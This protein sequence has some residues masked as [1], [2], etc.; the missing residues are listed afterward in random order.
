MFLLTKFIH[1]KN[2]DDKA[3]N[4]NGR[5]IYF[6]KLPS[7]NVG[8]DSEV[9]QKTGGSARVTEFDKLTKGEAVFDNDSNDA[10][11]SR[12][13]T[14]NN[15]IEEEKKEIGNI[16][17]MIKKQSK[18][19]DRAK[20]LLREKQLLIQ[21]EFDR[22]AYRFSNNE[23][24]SLMGE[25][26]SKMAHDIRNPLNVIKIQVDLLKLRFSKQEDRIMLD[27]LGRMERAVYGISNQL[28]DILN[29]LKDAPI[30]FENASILKILDESLF[31]LNIPEN[32]TLE[33]P[34]N[35]VTLFCDS[36]K[37]QRV[38]SNM[39]Q[40]SIQAI[41]NK[42]TITIAVSEKS[43]DIKITIKDTGPGIPDELMPK[44]FEPLFTTKKRGTGLGLTICKKI[45][46]DH[47]GSI[48]VA[49]DPTTFTIT[50]PKN[51]N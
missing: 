36:Y 13:T 11:Q 2:A 8:T 39:I 12:I 25:M 40:N 35:D 37:M 33:L 38:F 19:L 18:S 16:Q 41:E 21:T 31:D 10:R 34:K 30:H 47:N 3:P 15:L 50:I 43:D 48:A 7:E 42:G 20:K 5:I 14:I 44:I 49:N 26:S 27:S 17:T 45:I 32:I 28:D 9:Q 24:F 29:F 22:K 23:K 6:S 1:K 51:N 4:E 46:D